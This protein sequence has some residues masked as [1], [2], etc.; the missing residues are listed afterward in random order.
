M[1]FENIKGYNGDYKISKN[2]DIIS[3]KR[4]KK[5]ILL[6]SYKNNSGYLYVTLSNKG[7]TK[8][9]AVHRLVAE[10][11]IPNAYNKPTVNHLN[12]VKTD[13]RLNNLEWSTYHEQLKHSFDTKLRKNQCNIER[14][15]KLLTKKNVTE[16]KTLKDLSIFLNHK[17]GFINN[18]INRYG[19][20]F[21]I[22]DKLIIINSNKNYNNII[23]KEPTVNDIPLLHYCEINNINY[24]TVKDRIRRGWDIE[25]ATL[26]VS[27]K[28]R[29]EVV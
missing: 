8:R 23:Y 21:Y 6:K 28:Y 18:C 11:F 14:K 4:C 26:N 25:K 19:D 16:F 29:K 9:Y 20:K 27:S 22:K 10:T 17:R 7:I 1:E 15:C 12:G 5:G 13:N 2:G 24:R 3:Y